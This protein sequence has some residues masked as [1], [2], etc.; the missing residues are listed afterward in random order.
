MHQCIVGPTL[1]REKESYFIFEARGARI[2]QERVLKG[3]KS[4][5]HIACRLESKTPLGPT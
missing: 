1:C 3:I 4:A 5:I 2:K